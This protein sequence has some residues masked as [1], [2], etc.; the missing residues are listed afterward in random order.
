MSREFLEEIISEK[1]SESDTLEY[2]DYYFTNGKLTSLDQKELA[3][4]FKEICAL[5]NYNGEK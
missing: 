3:K 5:A 1:I 2:K 4:L